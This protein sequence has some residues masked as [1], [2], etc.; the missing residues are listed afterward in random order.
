[1]LHKSENGSRTS[2]GL[3]MAV[4]LLLATPAV[5]QSTGCDG[6]SILDEIKAKDAAAVARIDAAA[7]HNKNGRTLLWKIESEEFPD[8]PASY[9]YGTLHVTDA[10]LQAFSPAVEQALN[11]TSRIAMEV[12]ETSL[13][14]TQE[15]LGVMRTALLPAGS[16]KLATLLATPEAQRASVILAKAGLTSE[17]QTNARPWVATLLSSVSECEQRRL[18]QG[19]LTL[20]QEIARQAENRGVGSFGLESTEM[21]Y[22]AL[23]DVPDAEQVSLLKATLAAQ[24]RLDDVT[25]AMVQLYL[26]HDLGRIWPL[27]REVWLRFGASPKALDSFVQNAIEDRSLRMRDRTLMHLNTGGVF[28]AVGAVHLP[29]DKGLVE[30]IKEAGFKLTAL[31]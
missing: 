7:A 3:A 22:T 26:A 25:E 24:D 31:E 4:L 20:D 16:A 2:P 11:H 5:A 8:R 13:E 18:K 9:L 28:I 6:H 21:Q 19:K 27:Q 30:L 17:L 23:A 12:D 29:G 10:R 15:A 14:R 1:M